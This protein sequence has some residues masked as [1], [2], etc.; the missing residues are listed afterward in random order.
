M[1][2]KSTLMRQIAITAIM[3]Q[4]GS[5]VPADQ[6][7][8]PLFDH[9]FTRIGASDQLTEGLST[10]MV[11]MTETAE[12]LEKSTAKSLM[13]VDEIGRGTSTFDGMSLAQSILEY[14]LTRKAAMTVF[15]THYHELTLLEGRFPQLKNAHMSV[16]DKDG[17]IRFL[18]TLKSGPAQKSYGI[19]VAKLAGMPEMITTRAQALL[20]EAERKAA[21][22]AKTQNHQQLSLLEQVPA[23]HP[24]VDEIMSFP[25]QAKTPLETMNQVA[26]WQEILKQP[27]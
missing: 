5:F 6:A 7:E 21:P 11:E 25:V 14:I 23:K 3:A 13:I 20:L 2:G 8:L 24:I 22:A 1:A 27:N 15:A 12:M 19:Q 16:R 4:I 26:R 9:I 18:H 17:E 10:F